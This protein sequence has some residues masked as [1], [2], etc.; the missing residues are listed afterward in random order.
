MIVAATDATATAVATFA[1]FII[2]GIYEAERNA[3]FATAASAPPFV[4]AFGVG[5]AL[6][7]AFCVVCGL[8]YGF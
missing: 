3:G 4:A 7:L 1:A 8:I 6:L 2:Y 5:G